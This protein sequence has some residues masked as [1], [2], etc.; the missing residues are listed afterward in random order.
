MMFKEKSIGRTLLAVF[1]VSMLLIGVWPTGTIAGNSDTISENDQSVSGET[2]DSGI[3][4][5]PVPDEPS[6]PNNSPLMSHPERNRAHD[7]ERDR[8]S[9]REMLP[10]RERPSHEGYEVP[11]IIQIME[12]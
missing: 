6:G 8:N 11:D 9:V 1:I 5:A 7:F 2:A 4:A 12:L 3:D 10:D